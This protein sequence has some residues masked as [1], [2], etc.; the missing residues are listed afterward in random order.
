MKILVLQMKRAGDLIVTTPALKELR[1]CYP[2]AQ[3]TL[4][5]TSA[6]REILP[7]INSV[8]VKLMYRRGEPNWSL[9]RKVMFGN[10]D[11]CLDFT[12]TD[13]SALL[14]VLSKASRRITF[15]LIHKSR[16][17]PIFYNEF[18]DSPVR[19]HHTIDHYLHLLR[20]LDI[21]GP[22][23]ASIVLELPEWTHKKA[24]QV[25]A[26]ARLSPPFILVHPGTARREKYWLPERWAEI[27][28]ICVSELRLPVAI[29]GSNDSAEQDHIKRIRDALDVPHTDLS[30]RVDLL[31]LAA[32]VRRAKMFLS[33]DSAPMHL[34][35]ASSVPQVALFGPTNP[36]HW[37][38]R[39]D[40]A[41][42]ILAGEKESD[43]PLQ[44]RHELHPMSEISTH[45]VIDAISSLISRIA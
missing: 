8:D 25:L 11:V 21:E 30:G 24:R 20:P 35:A 34:A 33:V 13:R 28:K 10:Y 27:I 3:V 37:R 39:H 19:Q 9:W 2:D 32:L 23:D 45:Q 7:A 43:P 17:N 42:T 1:R 36:F 15:Q 12:G 44:P 5:T 6:V 38:P 18:V 22:K 4:A 40:R 26:E 41:I 14:T 16:F 31:T 29:S